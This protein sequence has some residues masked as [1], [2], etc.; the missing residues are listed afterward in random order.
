MYKK[1]QTAEGMQA[2]RTRG[3][4]APALFLVPLAGRSGVK[5]LKQMELAEKLSADTVHYL[6]DV[7][8]SLLLIIVLVLATPSPKPITKAKRDAAT[9]LVGVGSDLGMVEK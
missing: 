6:R 2:E 3:R 1:Q 8:S 4:D 5:L 9:K 7:S